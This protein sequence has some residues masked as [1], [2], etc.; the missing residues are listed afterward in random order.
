MRVESIPWS[1]FTDELA[2]SGQM[3]NK[4]WNSVKILDIQ[5]G[6]ARAATVFAAELQ[7]NR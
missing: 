7:N 5:S 1:L 6:N 4:S 2:V 3:S